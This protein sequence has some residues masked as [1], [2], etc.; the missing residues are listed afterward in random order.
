MY[1]CWHCLSA[2]FNCQQISMRGMAVVERRNMLEVCLE[3]FQV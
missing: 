3:N 2:Y 1:C